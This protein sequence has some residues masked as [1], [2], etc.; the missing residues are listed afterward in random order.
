MN[1]IIIRAVDGVLQTDYSVHELDIILKSTLRFLSGFMVQGVQYGITFNLCFTVNAGRSF[2]HIVKLKDISEFN[3]FI[4]SDY[5]G[6]LT[7]I[8]Y[9]RNDMKR[10]YLDNECE[11]KDIGV[12]LEEYR[13]LELLP[14]I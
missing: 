11:L 10:I 6:I 3:R 4:N 1:Y 12:K 5:L 8:N 7:Q 13:F 2:H 9:H 14:P